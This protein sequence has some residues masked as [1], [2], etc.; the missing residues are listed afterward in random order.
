MASLPGVE[1]PLTAD[2]LMMYEDQVNIW[3]EKEALL[4]EIVYNTVDN[5]TFIIK[6]QPTAA[7]MWEKLVSIHANKGSH[8][9]A[10]SLLGKLQNLCLTDDG[11]MREYICYMVS[12]R[13][14]LTEVGAPLTNEQFNAYIKTSLSFASCYHPVLT[15]QNHYQ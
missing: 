15:S 3:E 13:E 5:S 2:D 12:L 1:T 6:G 4:R 10:L 8:Q 7:R 14:R 9:F 11:N